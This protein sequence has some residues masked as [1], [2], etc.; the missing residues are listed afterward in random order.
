[1][2]DNLFRVCFRTQLLELRRCQVAE[3]RMES[4][5]VVVTLP[6]LDHDLGIDPVTEP[7]NAQAF[8]PELAVETL[9]R[10]VLPRLAGVDIGGLDF[11]LV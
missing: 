2:E 3:T 9:P 8:V 1:M 6:V 4:G 11:R 7:L 10:G 5:V